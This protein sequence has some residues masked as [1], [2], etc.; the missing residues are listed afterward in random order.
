VDPRPDL[1][2]I[3]AADPS[4]VSKCPEHRWENSCP[5]PDAA[6]A[7]RCSQ[8]G[9]E[10]RLDRLAM[11]HKHEKRCRKDTWCLKKSCCQ[12]TAPQTTRTFNSRIRM[13]VS[14]PHPAARF[15]PQAPG[16]KLP[17]TTTAKGGSKKSQICGPSPYR[18]HFSGKV[19]PC[20][21]HLGNDKNHLGQPW[22]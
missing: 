10:D 3:F 14:L 16:A 4:P 6:I 20:H 12:A 11:C 8:C 7:H 13:P 18:P 2:S 22:A 21:N 9:S 19:R 17:S 5:Y 1:F 15:R